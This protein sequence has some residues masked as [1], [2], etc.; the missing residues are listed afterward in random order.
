MVDIDKQWYWDRRN[1]KAYYPVETDE[2]T[3]RFVTVWHEQEVADAVERGALAP[4]E[5]IGLDRTE[6]TF[7]LI[8]SFRTPD[9]TEI[10]DTDSAGGGGD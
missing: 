2:G 4:I 3:V 6:T 9:D 5:E 8:D 1:D 7:D 10:E